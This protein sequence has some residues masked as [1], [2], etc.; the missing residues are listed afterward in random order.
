MEFKKQ[1]IL[2]YIVLGLF[3]MNFIQGMGFKAANQQAVKT[4]TD[5]SC[6]TYKDCPTCVGGFSGQ[7]NTYDTS[8]MTIFDE[9]SYANCVSGKCQLSEYCITW[10]CG[11]Q[12]ASVCPSIKQTLYDNTIAK[13]QANPMILLFVVAGLI[14]YLML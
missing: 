4:Y 5:F 6:T 10:D 12:P 1:H 3:A 14:A 9:L 2:V 8:N 11:T 13:I 7:S